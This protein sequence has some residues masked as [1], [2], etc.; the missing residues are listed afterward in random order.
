M[1]AYEEFSR[2]RQ[3]ADMVLL[4][5]VQVPGTRSR[6]CYGVVCPAAVGRWS[7]IHGRRV[8]QGR[9]GQALRI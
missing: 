2:A 8:A 9:T 4:E 3:R 7:T 1:H 6:F 5:L